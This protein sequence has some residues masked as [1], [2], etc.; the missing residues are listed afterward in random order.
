[1]HLLYLQPCGILG[2]FPTTTNVSCV[3]EQDVVIAPHAWLLGAE[4]M[5]L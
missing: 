3:G 2:Y 1:M 4:A 5:V